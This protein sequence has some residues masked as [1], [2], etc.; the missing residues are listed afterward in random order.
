[1]ASPATTTSRTIGVSAEEGPAKDVRKEYGVYVD[2]TGAK[3]KT[4]S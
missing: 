4:S 1:M 3:A 2:E